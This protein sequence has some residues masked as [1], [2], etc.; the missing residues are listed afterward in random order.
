MRV[1][2]LCPRKNIPFNHPQINA[3]QAD[4]LWKIFL[5]KKEEKKTV[6][7]F[8]FGLGTTKPQWMA[9]WEDEG[10]TFVAEDAQPLV[11]YH[12]EVIVK[13]DTC[14]V[15]ILNFFDWE[16]WAQRAGK[17]I[18]SEIKCQPTSVSLP[19]SATQVDSPHCV[20]CRQVFPPL[21]RWLQNYKAR[22]VKKKLFVCPSH[23]YQPSQLAELIWIF[24]KKN[25]NKKFPIS[26]K[27]ENVKNQKTKSSSSWRQR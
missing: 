12:E 19:G 26:K 24:Y 8:F 2:Y 21:L 5:G 22:K 18:S 17:P 23:R 9:M 3:L 14:S 13:P 25:Q 1:I 11:D 4:N 7:R 6:K 15:D 10:E 27:Q 16:W 20:L